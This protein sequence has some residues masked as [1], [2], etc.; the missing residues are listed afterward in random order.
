MKEAVKPLAD[1]FQPRP[2]RFPASPNEMAMPRQA[3]FTVQWLKR[4][5]MRLNF[6]ILKLQFSIYKKS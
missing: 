1:G 4:V 3:R 6:G 5:R 2:K